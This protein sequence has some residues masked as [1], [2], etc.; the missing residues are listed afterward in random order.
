MRL[1]WLAILI[2]MP[3]SAQKEV[4]Q[5]HRWEQN[6]T[7][8]R[9]YTADGGN[10]YRDLVV[11][12]TFTRDSPHL[13]ISG[14]G[15]WDGGRTFKVRTA[16]P[17][18][19]WRWRASCIGTTGGQTCGG[20]D[21]SDRDRGLWRSGRFRV[22]RATRASDLPAIYRRGFLRVSNPEPGSP[23]YLTYGDGTPFYWLGD[24]AWQAPVS[25]TA[26]EWNAFLENRRAKGFSVVLTA[27]ATQYTGAI[28]SFEQVGDCP[29]AAIPNACSRWLPAYW[30]SFDG[31]VEQANRAGIV[32][33]L[34]GLVNP[35]GRGGG[36]SPELY[37]AVDDAV[38]FSRN[39]AARLAGNFVV[40]SPGFDDRIDLVRAS[41]EAV[42]RELERAVPRHLVTNH[43][44]GAS[45]AEDYAVFEEQR[46][47]DFQLFQ[48]GHALNPRACAGKT[49]QQCAAERARQ[50][51]LALRQPRLTKPDINGEGAYEYP[52]DSTAAPPDNRFGVRQ[53]AYSSVLSGA[54][55]FTLGVKGL[56]DWSAPLAVLDSP[57]SFDMVYL[58]SRFRRRPWQEMRPLPESILN[59]QGLSPQRQMSLAATSDA[60]FAVAYL[61]NNDAIEIAVAGFPGLSC[62]PPW[63]KLWID[64]RTGRT[65]LAETCTG[66]P[67]SITLTRPPCADPDPDAT[68]ACDWVL[69]LRNTRSSASA[70]QVWTAIEP[71]G[72]TSAILARLA[73]RDIVVSPAGQAFQDDP[74][75]ERDARGRFFVVWRSELPGGGSRTWGRRFD[76]EGRPL[77]EAFRVRFQRGNR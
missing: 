2:A 73:G 59:N 16:L 41:M 60:G 38:V 29:S 62:D 74:T 64:P 22:V 6:L 55:G 63:T 61:P 31:L 72:R 23:P 66:S 10:P 49:R 50:L 27:P 25:A 47:L 56:F 28:T 67:A 36:R 11:R 51:P 76:G 12:V 53:T 57:A 52:Q 68:G 70:V 21:S 37:P 65:S 20:A 58:A 35:V 71:D 8:A 15:F 40:F 3:A 34:A 43:L 42:G 13:R 39:V 33:V 18:G 44:A 32:V 46:W 7:S 45:P 69:E 9:D 17:P 30:Q 1:L 4:V 24:T 48:S 54:F 14:Y 19:T 75:V 5:W 26:A 77:G